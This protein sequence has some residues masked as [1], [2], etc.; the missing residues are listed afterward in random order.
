[1]IVYAMGFLITM[2]AMENSFDMVETPQNPLAPLAA[3]M[4]PLLIVALFI[5]W[6]EGK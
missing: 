6:L 4:W 3:M 2:K 1:M 5:D